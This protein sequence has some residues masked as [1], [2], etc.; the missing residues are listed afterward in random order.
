MN[1]IKEVLKKLLIAVITGAIILGFVYYKDNYLSQESSDMEM[2]QSVTLEKEEK[3]EKV[4]KNEIEEE[5]LSIE[6]EVPE[7]TIETEN[8]IVKTEKFKQ[9]P[10]P[11]KEQSFDE[12]KNSMSIGSNQDKFDELEK[13]TVNF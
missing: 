1:F 4:V 9:I 12:F 13:E 10:K 3:T 2:L 6:V 5:P 8:T 11:N 7:V